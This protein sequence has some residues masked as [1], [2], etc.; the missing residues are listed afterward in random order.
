MRRLAWKL[1]PGLYRLW[2]YGSWFDMGWAIIFG[3][4]FNCALVFN[5]VWTEVLGPQGNMV[6]WVMLGIMWAVSLF[7]SETNASET[8]SYN[9]SKKHPKADFF[10]DA[11]THYLK[12]NWLEAE[13]ILV[14]MLSENQKDAEA[15]L[16]LATLYRRTK[17]YQEAEQQLT[18]LRKWRGAE[19]WWTEIE[20]ETRV[21]T[22]MRNSQAGAERDP[23]LPEAE[24]RLSQ[25]PKA[26]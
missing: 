5:L 6:L 19:S 23:P 21:I 14:E 20:R 22:D 26:A 13:Q 18:I 11:Q 16:L 10:R 1:W 9:D 8:A 12:R 2:N 7:S 3:L 4:L 17:R 15:R 24:K 25:M